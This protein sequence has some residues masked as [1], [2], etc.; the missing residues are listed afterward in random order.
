[1]GFKLAM[2][3]RMYGVPIHVVKIDYFLPSAPKQCS[4]CNATILNSGLLYFIPLYNK[5]LSKITMLFLIW[6]KVCIFL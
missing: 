5:S 4:H 3:S 2:W 1:L 6:A